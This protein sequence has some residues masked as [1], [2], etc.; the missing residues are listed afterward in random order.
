MDK[1]QLARIH[2]VRTLQLGLTRAEEAAEHAR[3]ASEA[4]LR[5]R[6]VQLADA[7]APAP[8]A[9]EGFTFA[10]AAH[11]RERLHV[12]AQ[13]AEARLATATARVAAAVPQA[14]QQP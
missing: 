11:F 13:A 4:A 3:H 10:A 5:N 14:L 6:I 1:K 9:A 12:S 8:Q 7:I 2:R